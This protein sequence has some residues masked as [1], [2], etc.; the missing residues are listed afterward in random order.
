MMCVDLKRHFN[1]LKVAVM[2]VLAVMV[3][4]FVLTAAGLV[5]RELLNYW[6]SLWR[7]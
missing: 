4:M 3:M 2:A 1:W 6:K 5:L 7:V